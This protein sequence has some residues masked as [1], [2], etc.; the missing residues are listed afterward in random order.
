MTA[1]LRQAFER[2]SS[3]TGDTLALPPV[4]MSLAAHMA[5]CLLCLQW[6]QTGSA[7]LHTPEGKVY[8]SAS[9]VYKNICDVIFAFG[10]Y[11]SKAYTTDLN[12]YRKKW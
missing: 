1:Q 4:E 6:N 7:I 5:D 11:T 8:G 3:V 2:R 10:F 9:H 12:Q